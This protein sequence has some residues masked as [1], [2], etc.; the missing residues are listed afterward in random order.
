MRTSHNNVNFLKNAANELCGISLGYDFCAEHEWGI[1][2]LKTLF[3]VC[4]DD[5]VESNVLGVDRYKV[6][7]FPQESVTFE[8]CTKTIDKVEH[9]VAY[10]LCEKSY[11]NKRERPPFSFWRDN[12]LICEWDERS[13]RIQVL[14]EENIEYLRQIYEAMQKCDIAFGNFSSKNP[15]DRGGLG[16]TIVSKIDK[17][18]LD[19][20]LAEDL[21]YKRLQCEAKPWLEK[22]KT[23]SGDWLDNNKVSWLA[24]SPKYDG[25]GKLKFW[26]NPYKQDKYSFGW[27]T[28][29]EILEWCQTCAGKPLADKNRERAD[30]ASKTT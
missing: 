8:V 21:N 7:T 30:K 16:I 28:P 12:K 14:G 22:F 6:T 20:Q 27:Y 18:M 2:G 26:L 17:E 4:Q 25:D 3:G 11:F 5:I 24:L 1:K 23:Y 13:F 19:K 15:F 10:L 9:K 29:E